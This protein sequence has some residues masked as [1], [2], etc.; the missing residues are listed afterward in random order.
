MRVR[1]G[2]QVREDFLIVRERQRIMRPDDND[3]IISTWKTAAKQA[4]RF[5]QKSFHAVSSHG[6]A[7]PARYA[8]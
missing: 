7:N 1:S 4:N 3:Q 2:D 6:V 8:Q 5:P